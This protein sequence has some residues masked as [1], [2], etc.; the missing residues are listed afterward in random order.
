M[1]AIEGLPKQPV[2]HHNLWPL[3]VAA[4]SDAD[5]RIESAALLRFACVKN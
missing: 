1:H 4:S 2:I 3:D 5:C